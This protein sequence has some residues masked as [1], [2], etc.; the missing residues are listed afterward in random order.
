MDERDPE[1]IG[2]IV[3]GW[4]SGAPEAQRDAQSRALIW[5]LGLQRQVKRVRTARLDFMAEHE[6]TV[7]R[8]VYDDES[9]EPPR[10]MQAEILMMFIAAGQLLRALDAFDG[11]RRPSEGLDP[12]RVKTLRNALEH[13]DDPN[14]RAQTRLAAA[15]VDPL[16][17][18]WRPDGSGI[19]GDV[20]D[21]DL[22]IWAAAVYDD[23]K[24]WDPW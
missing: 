15:G 24:A 9:A 2:A 19:V 10:R 23:V 13:W 5:A 6:R 21:V 12:E 22:E 18:R 17:N 20:D 7:S 16:N 11:D 4:S 14:G 1:Q 8:G 3:L